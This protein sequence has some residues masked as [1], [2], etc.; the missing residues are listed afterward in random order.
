MAGIYFHIPFCKQACSYCDFHFSTSLRYADEMIEAMKTEISLR[1]GFISGEK[2]PI[3]ESIYFG[4]GTPSIISTKKIIELIDEA[5]KHFEISNEI[6]ITLEANPNDLTKQKI[7]EIR[8]TPINRFSIGIQ[9]FHDDDLHFLKRAHNSIDASDCVKRAQD[10]GFENLT[11]DLI[12]GIPILTN[13]KWKENISAAI[14]LQ[15]PHISAYC[16][17]RENKTLLNHWINK[18]MSPSLND[19]QDAEQ[20]IILMKELK[21]AGFEQYEISNFAK[22]KKYSKHNSAYWKGVP[23]LGIGPSAH[24]FNGDTRFYSVANN[25]QYLKG[26]YNKDVIGETEVLSKRDKYNEYVM[27]RLRTMWGVNLIYITSEF[28]ADYLRHFNKEIAIHKLTKKVE[29]KQNI[30]TLTNEGKLMADAISSDLFKVKNE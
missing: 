27:T 2:K 7:A 12:Y 19:E 13:K 9:S 1:K 29:E 5:A 4:G 17:T 28:G 26:V 3:I 8:N 15:V 23:Y 24:S 11:I 20:L 18:G 25:P 10:A 30:I 6:E 22:E 14:N 16:L 21:I